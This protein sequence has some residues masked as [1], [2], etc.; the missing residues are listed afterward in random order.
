MRYAMAPLRRIPVPLRRSIGL[1]LIALCALPC[2]FA[3]K[4]H[5]P[6]RA[7]QQSIEAIERQIRTALLS[8]DVTILD[9]V[10]ADDFLGISSNG[11]L[12]N[13]QQY[14]SRIVKHEHAFQ[15]IDVKETKVR[16]QRTS[17]VVTSLA[18]VAGDF[19]GKPMQGVF[20]YTRVYEKQGNGLW[21]VINFEATR[22][23]GPNGGDLRN[24][25]PLRR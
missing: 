11:T 12:S 4:Q 21:R 19:D 20:R 14:V 22:V 18:N 5:K 8:G 3:V 6:G 23:S 15:R 2:A 25:I 10:L 9:R 13:K 1:L 7:D 17:A 24:G 16:V